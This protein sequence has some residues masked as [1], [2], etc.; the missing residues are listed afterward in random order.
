MFQLRKKA[1]WPRDSSN[2]SPE[3][4]TGGDLTS[5]THTKKAMEIPWAWCKKNQH[6]CSCEVSTGHVEKIKITQVLQISIIIHDHPWS[7]NLL[8][9]SCKLL[10]LPVA[11]W[12]IP[13]GTCP[14][15]ESQS[16]SLDN[17]LKFTKIALWIPS[18]NGMSFKKGQHPLPPVIIPGLLSLFQVDSYLYFLSSINLA[19]GELEITMFWSSANRG[20]WRISQF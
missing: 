3:R 18:T 4:K 19:F 14:R 16:G 9:R 7:I 13:L 1:P 11:P 10:R 5:R 6:R 17:F 12:T 2:G 15:R 20:P 8:Q